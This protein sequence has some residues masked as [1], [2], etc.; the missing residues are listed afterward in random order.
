MSLDFDERR[1][2]QRLQL[3]HPMKITEQATGREHRGL[4]RDLSAIGLSFH[5]NTALPVGTLLTVAIDPAGQSAVLPFRA[6]AEVHRV[7]AE[8]GGYLVAARILRML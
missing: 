2:F 5:L 1:D 4:G 6:E 3:D 7:E 8:G